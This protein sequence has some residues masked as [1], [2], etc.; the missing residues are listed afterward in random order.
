MLAHVKIKEGDKS[1]SKVLFDDEVNT[2]RI[3]TMVS[4]AVA[5]RHVVTISPR[6][7]TK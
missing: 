3:P 6:T 2:Q 5:K 7:E 4:K 1:N